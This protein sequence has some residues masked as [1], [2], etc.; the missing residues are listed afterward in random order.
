MSSRAPHSV[1]SRMDGVS[2]FKPKYLFLL[3]LNIGFFQAGQKKKNFAG[4]SGFSLGPLGHSGSKINCTVQ[5]PT[6]IGHTVFV[7]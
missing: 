5:T 7:M 2:S 3:V 6:L 4:L 1:S